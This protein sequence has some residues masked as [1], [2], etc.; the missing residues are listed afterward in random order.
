MSTVPASITP[1][2]SAANTPSTGSTNNAVSSALL[3]STD[4]LQILLAEFQN[5]D[6]TS[7]TDP[8]QFATQLVQ[9]ANLGQLENIDQAVQP[10]NSS[11]LMQAASA[12]LGR[13]VVT[14]GNAVGVANNKAT[15]I[16]FA[17]PASDSYT[18][19]VYNASGQQVDSVSLGGQTAGALQTFTWK[20][21]SAQPDG[22]YSVAIVNSTGA[23]VNGLVEQGVV[24][25]VA[26]TSGTVELNLGNLIIGTNQVT[27]V[28]SASSN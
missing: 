3:S 28:S 11:D 1:T 4:F 22:Q 24:Q 8:T 20:P 16:T 9:F 18:A 6:P 21:S 27:S 14:P 12:F 26:M 17:V 25:S 5:Q 7:P 19:L 10:N 13:E 23:P 15:S 2:S